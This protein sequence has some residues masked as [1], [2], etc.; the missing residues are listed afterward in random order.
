MS[1]TAWLAVSIIGF[2]LAA[3]C[4]GFAVW[5]FIWYKIPTVISDL[6]GHRAAKE[7]AELRGDRQEAKRNLENTDRASD[8]KAMALAHESKRL[9]IRSADLEGS[10]PT[11][12]FGP[13]NPNYSEL[14]PGVTGVLNEPVQTG[15]TQVLNET[16]EAIIPERPE[17]E[18]PRTED[19]KEVARFVIVR[20]VT[21]VHTDEYV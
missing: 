11:E 10:S 8:F 5:Y 7:V 12:A 19:L 15:I 14:K 9:D 3:I 13:D 17:E 21:E 16:G 2:S 4:F 20:S 1:T 6:S 18:A